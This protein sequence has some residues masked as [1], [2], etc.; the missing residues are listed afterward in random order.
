[1]TELV[2]VHR[3]LT[4]LDAL[5]NKIR[6][7]IGL[8]QLG[9]LPWTNSAF[10]M[11]PNSLNFLVVLNRDENGDRQVREIELTAT[12]AVESKLSPL[13]G[14]VLKFETNLL[15]KWAPGQLANLQGFTLTQEN[16]VIRMVVDYLYSVRTPL[17]TP[18]K[19]TWIDWIPAK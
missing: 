1:M 11:R 6:V 3:T 19:N 7:H 13:K 4:T 18:R 15:S 16:L 5:F 8:A 10:S 9:E 2:D 12:P 14:I 17:E